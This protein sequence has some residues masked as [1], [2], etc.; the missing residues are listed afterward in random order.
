MVAPIYSLHQCWDL[1][2]EWLMMIINKEFK[3]SSGEKV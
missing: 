3:G 1:T 2:L